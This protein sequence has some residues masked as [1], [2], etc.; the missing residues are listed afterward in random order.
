[1]RGRDAGASGCGAR[2]RPEWTTRMRRVI[3]SDVTAEI[4]ARSRRT[5]RTSRSEFCRLDTSQLPRDRQRRPPPCLR[6]SRRTLHSRDADAGCGARRRPQWTT[7]MSRMSHSC[8]LIDD[9]DESEVSLAGCRERPV[10]RPRHGCRV[11]GCRV[12]PRD[13]RR[14]PR[15]H[16][17]PVGRT[18]HGCHVIR[19]DARPSVT[20]GTTAPPRVASLHLL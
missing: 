19:S 16:R 3:W 18:R 17:R 6:R 8:Y 1:V 9:S 7:R 12:I 11:I 5:T 15:D 13:H 14:L 2:P 10:G 4:T 20:T